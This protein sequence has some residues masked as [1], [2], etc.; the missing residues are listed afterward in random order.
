[1]DWKDPEITPLERG[2]MLISHSG[3]SL[4]TSFPPSLSFASSVTATQ[5]G[6]LT[7]TTW[8]QSHRSS[9]RSRWQPASLPSLLSSLSVYI[10]LYSF[11]F[12]NPFIFF[13]CPHWTARPFF[14]LPVCPSPP[15]QDTQSTSALPDDSGS[16]LMDDTASQWSAAADSEE[17]RKSALEKSMYVFLRCRSCL[18]AHK[19]VL[20]SIKDYLGCK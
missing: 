4:H 11:F 3:L 7:V 18:D 6:S 9:P 12:V 14:C 8:I 5:H 15:Q 10:Y 2:L 1:M 13:F 19:D 17:E 16:V 20:S